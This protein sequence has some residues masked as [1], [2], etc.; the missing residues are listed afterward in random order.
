ENEHQ[1][2]PGAFPGAQ[3][4]VGLPPGTYA[5]HRAGG[6][7]E[8]YAAGPKAAAPALPAQIPLSTPQH[9]R[10]I[11]VGAQGGSG[12]QYRVIAKPSDAGPGTMVIAVPLSDLSS[13]LTRLR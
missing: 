3:P 10:L 2:G 8:R 11:T 7:E 9:P 12:L 13:T 4:G 5:F 1:G 6:R